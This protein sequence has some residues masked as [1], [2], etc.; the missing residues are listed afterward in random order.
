[1]CVNCTRSKGTPNGKFLDK[2]NPP[3]NK[4]LPVP[5]SSPKM[6]AMKTIAAFSLQ[7]VAAVLDTLAAGRSPER[8]ALLAAA[9]TLTAHCGCTLPTRDMQD[10]AAALETLA[11]G[12]TLD[13]D[14]AGRQRAAKLAHI[15]RQEAAPNTR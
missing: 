10:A 6:M 15:I 8:A 3:E 13:L 7:D 4:R 1:M 2:V 9:L 5:K 14:A 12:G 11:T